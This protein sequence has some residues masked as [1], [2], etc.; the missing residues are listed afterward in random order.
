MVLSMTALCAVTVLADAGETKPAVDGRFDEWS[1]TPPAWTDPSGDGD[2]I[3]FQRIWVRS[4]SDRLT[5]RFEVGSEINL[6]DGNSITLLIDGDADPSTGH[7][8]GGLG[9]ELVWVFGEREGVIADG[10]RE[11]AVH[12]SEIGLRQAPTVSSTEFEVSLLRRTDGGAPVAC[13]PRASVALLDGR[14]E[15]GDRL[16]DRGAVAIALSNAPP[17]SPP[18]VKLERRSRND[19]RVLSYNVLRDGLFNRPT[20][21]F[22][23]LRAVEPDVICLQEV[24]DHTAEESAEQIAIA[25]PDATWHGAGTDDCQ[26]VS[27]YPVIESRAIG[28]TENSW[29]L[30]DLPDDRYSIDL[31]IVSAHPPCCN[32]E[33]DRQAELDA[34]AA[35]T[36]DLVGPTGRGLPKRTPIVVAGDMNLV[37]GARQLE[38]LLAGEIVDEATHGTSG[39][40]DWDGSPL[41]DAVP[42]HAGGYDTFT[43]RDAGSSFAPG[44][45][46]YI[47]YSDSVLELGNAFV[48]AAEELAP[49]ILERYGL[50]PGDT[51]EASD[52]LPVVADF[53]PITQE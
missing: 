51:L 24:W 17:S 40:P 21:F 9:A 8:V 1:D 29:A 47:V 31:S 26:I 28:G 48:L 7:S 35:W 16:P 46:D 13:A 30:I 11:R 5:I 15:R 43:W 52:H 14:G 22:R 53:A 34:M 6:Q 27:R 3:D 36:R 39:H 32:N 19:I 50:W 38:T 23:V 12:Q 10:G 33:K 18:D 20:P 49:E 25:L 42:R 2:R 4:D 41:E 45:L 37:G 44:R